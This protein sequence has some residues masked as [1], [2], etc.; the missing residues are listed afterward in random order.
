MRC[1]LKNIN[2]VKTV[3]TSVRENAKRYGVIVAQVATALQDVV[4]LELVVFHRVVK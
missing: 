4:T 1:I 2:S 3:P